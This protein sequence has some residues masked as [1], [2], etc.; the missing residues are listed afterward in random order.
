MRSPTCAP[1]MNH[2]HTT[3][4]TTDRTTQASTINPAIRRDMPINRLTQKVVDVF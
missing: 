4:V 3:A 1:R 2:A